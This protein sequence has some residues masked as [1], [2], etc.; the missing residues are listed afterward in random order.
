MRWD[1]YVLIEDGRL[2]DFWRGHLATFKRNVLW[3]IGKGF[4]RRALKALRRFCALDA[5][6]NVWLLTFKDGQPEG[7]RSRDLTTKNYDELLTLVDRANISELSIDIELNGQP[8]STSKNT[9]RAL[10]SQ[11]MLTDVDDIVIDISA[12]P[13]T[14]AMSAIAQ[15][16][17]DV[18]SEAS[19]SRST[20]VHVVVAESVSADSQAVGNLMDEVSSLDGFSGRLNEETTEGVPRVWFPILGEQQHDRLRL[21]QDHL[22]PDEIC[23]LV[24]FPSRDPRRG[25]RIIAEHMELLFDEFQ[26]EPSNVLRVSEFNPFEAYRQLYT[27]IDRYNESLSELGGCKAFVSPLSSK[28]LSVGALLACYD[29]QFGE[30]ESS[31]PNVGIRYVETA[32]YADPSEVELESKL[33]SMWIVGEWER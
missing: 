29:H 24:P 33:Y 22:D 26:V 19:A 6:P 18:D 20:N 7:E 4:D 11:G 3:L 12:M 15:L 32:A 2:E 13:R 28:L 1:P 5:N 17:Y 27:T 14:V 23:P 21:I 8:N 9:R 31:R 10:A 30:R 25:D 16:L